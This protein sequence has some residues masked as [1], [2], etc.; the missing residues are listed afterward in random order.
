MPRAGLFGIAEAFE[1][2]RRLVRKLDREPEA[3][4]HGLDVATQVEIMRSLR[5][6]SWAIVA[7]RM[8]RL[9]ASCA[10]VRS[11]CF[12]QILERL[13]FGMKPVRLGL[14]PRGARARAVLSFSVVPIGSSF[15]ATSQSVDGRRR[16]DQINEGVNGEVGLA[17]DRAQDRAFE[18]AR[19]N[20]NADEKLGAPRML[21]VVVTALHAEKLEARP[22]QRPDYLPGLER[23]ELAAHPGI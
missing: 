6:S 13:I 9:S 4:A 18:I 20:G 8:P 3:A 1:R 15:A 10:W 11:L 16:S 19:V 14:D 5:F 2:D 12:A 22:L 21:E 17:N 7:W 23:R